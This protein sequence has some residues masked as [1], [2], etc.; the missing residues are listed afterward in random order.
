MAFNYNFKTNRHHHIRRYDNMLGRREQKEKN[1]KISR[2]FED[3]YGINTGLLLTG[4]SSYITRFHDV[5]ARL[6]NVNHSIGKCC[7]ECGEFFFARKNQTYCS[8]VC[9]ARAWTRRKHEMTLKLAYR[10]C[11]PQQIKEFYQKWNNFAL[12]EIY[13]YPNYHD[14]LIERWSTVSGIYVLKYCIKSGLDINSKVLVKLIRNQIKYNY[15]EF[16]KQRKDEVFYD[17][18]NYKVRYKILGDVHDDL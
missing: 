8:K 7:P 1:A 18:C 14:D 13:N 17:E 5:V 10:V 16:K 4:Q 12:S 2:Y 6:C 11:K 3:V 9:G 15:L